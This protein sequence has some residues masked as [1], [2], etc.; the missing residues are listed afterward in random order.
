[1]PIYRNY[2]WVSVSCRQWVGNKLTA[3]RAWV[4]SRRRSLPRF[5]SASTAISQPVKKT[6]WVAFVL[7]STTMS[8]TNF[9]G[10]AR[11]AQPPLDGELL[12]TRADHPANYMLCAK[13]KV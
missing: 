6:W 3:V 1:M 5:S 9:G 13:S 12:H 7:S 10:V 11:A 2:Q 8:E 4:W